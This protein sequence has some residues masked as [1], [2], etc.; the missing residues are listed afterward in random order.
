[1]S[2]SGSTSAGRRDERVGAV[3]DGRRDEE[4]EV[5]ELVPAEGER[6]QVLAL[7]PDVDAAAERAENRSSRWSGDGPS[8]SGKRGSAAIAAA[9]RAGASP[10]RSPVLRCRDR[11]PPTRHAR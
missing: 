5:P 4:L 7:D 6:Q 2:G 1:V 10:H 3:R 11:H 9:H 8:S